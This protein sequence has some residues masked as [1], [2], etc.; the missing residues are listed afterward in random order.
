MATLGEVSGNSSDMSSSNFYTASHFSGSSYY[1]NES[2]LIQ[3]SNGSSMSMD[4]CLAGMKNS[5]SFLIERND[6]LDKETSEEN[7][8]ESAGYVT[9]AV[10]LDMDSHPI[11]GSKMSAPDSIVED[12]CNN[13]SGKSK[14]RSRS[15]NAVLKNIRNL[16]PKKNRQLS[17][18]SNEEEDGNN[19]LVGQS[20]SSCSSEDD[21][22]ASQELNGGVTSKLD[23]NSIGPAALNLKG[24][25]RARRGSATDPQS[26]YA[27]KR[28]ERI[29]ER[30]R[31]LQNLVPNGTKVDISTMLEEAVHY[32]KF[33]QH[34]IKLLSSDDLWMYTP[35][36]YNG[37]NIGLV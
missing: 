7:A 27:R 5:S 31:I 16:Q 17:W 1:M 21:P 36:A 32:V 6:C 8:E 18:P 4:F 34:Q 20:L 10:S 2:H 22:K 14:K 33:L 30:L 28:R 3:N 9:E 35:I 24:K 19:G 11:R 13:S 37:I 12:K 26:L 15:S 29:N 23:S 25:T